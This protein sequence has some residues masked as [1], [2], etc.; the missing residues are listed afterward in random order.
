MAQ[1]DGW[2][3][4]GIAESEVRPWSPQLMNLLQLMQHLAELRCSSPQLMQL[5]GE[6]MQRPGDLRQP[7]ELM[8][9]PGGLLSSIVCRRTADRTRCTLAYRRR[10]LSK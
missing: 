6:L 9:L 5:P 10:V 1:P 2:T 3:A 8:Q 4:N 7:G